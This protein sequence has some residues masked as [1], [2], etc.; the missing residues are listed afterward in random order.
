MLKRCIY[1]ILSGVVAS[2]AVWAG[3]PR[4]AADNHQV[5]EPK[6]VSQPTEK[7]ADEGGEPAFHESVAAL[8]DAGDDELN[9]D[10]LG[11][12]TDDSIS[13]ALEPDDGVR[14]R[15][16]TPDVVPLMDVPETKADGDKVNALAA[17]AKLDA[18][19]Q[20]RTLAIVDLRNGKVV[21]SAEEDAA[22]ELMEKIRSAGNQKSGLEYRIAGDKAMRYAWYCLDD[23]AEK[24]LLAERGM[25]FDFPAEF[26]VEARC[27][28]ADKE[29]FTCGGVAANSVALFGAS[30]CSLDDARTAIL[31]AIKTQQADSG[32][33]EANG[34][35][36]K[37]V[38]KGLKSSCE[39]VSYAEAAVR[40]QEPAALVVGDT[41]IVKK[42]SYS[43][44]AIGLSIGAGLLMILLGFVCTRR[45][46]EQPDTDERMDALRKEYDN[47]KRER[48]NALRE[49]NELGAE[50]E[51]LK[52]EAEESSEKVKQLQDELDS[53]KAD[54]QKE[55][56]M[57]MSLAE[58]NKRLED[59][60][61][62]NKKQQTV[63]ESPIKF[64][65]G[66]SNSNIPNVPQAGIPDSTEKKT[67]DLSH[68]TTETNRVTAQA[69]NDGIEELTSK[70]KSQA[71]FD[72]L[73]DDG[74]D[75]I[76]E[77]FD[78]I[79]TKPANKGDGSDS[80][81]AE[82]AEDGN[83]RSYGISEFLNMLNE[84][85]IR[86]EAELSDAPSLPKDTFQGMS[87]V[88]SGVK[89]TTLASIP[90][91]SPKSVPTLKTVP[92][93]QQKVAVEPNMRRNTLFGI[94]SFNSTNKSKS[95]QTSTAFM[96][97]KSNDSGNTT[98]TPGGSG[99]HRSAPTA[100]GQSMENNPGITMQPMTAAYVEKAD[101]SFKPAPSWTGKSLSS[102]GV[103][104]NSLY[105][106]LKRRA[107]DVSE[108]DMAAAEVKKDQAGANSGAF[109]YNRGLSRSGV[110]SVTGS[111]V[112]IDPL[113][114]NE[115]FKSLYE[116]YIELQKQCGESTNKF[117]QEQFVS[118][119]AREKE[120][121]IKTYKCRTVRFT[122]Y[123]KEGKA[124]LK[125]TPQK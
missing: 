96:G 27:E 15:L 22:L 56:L 52:K 19:K 9:A 98:L 75:E 65:A 35:T 31:S 99:E 57:R 33:V 45:K 12:G 63:V 71:F 62:A 28:M 78:A 87:S 95:S 112:D 79:F 70:E 94:G 54:Y 113:S 91:L 43:L 90:S 108:L 48:I 61:A 97:S 51:K 107:K 66:S 119:L 67:E 38:R 104:Q 25:T 82:G 46:E 10:M 116:K 20:V 44:Q 114:D 69:T 30:D 39:L 115:Y 122:V 18:F 105:N 80:K 120:R 11:A 37:F 49:K 109:E 34:K 81:N 1:I 8:I 118:R 5:T 64:T 124:S 110:F 26:P 42:D 7:I 84:D 23:D 100:M 72:A 50:V 13:G 40:T 103:D 29:F 92:N 68:P 24:C 32:I 16:A 55:Q 102:D 73:S 76:A 2:V 53:A 125:A 85:D 77:S 60:A 14:I 111:R 93:L 121:L 86:Q 21:E 4:L 117:T 58:D 17:M 47:V 59:A 41:P 36:W 6:P 101:E 123:V 74:W 88:P 83:E 3:M 89:K 106:A